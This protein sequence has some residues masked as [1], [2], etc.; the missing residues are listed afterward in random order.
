M[1]VVPVPVIT[2]EREG[3]ICGGRGGE[4]SLQGASFSLCEKSEDV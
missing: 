4:K 2:R 1:S 3:K